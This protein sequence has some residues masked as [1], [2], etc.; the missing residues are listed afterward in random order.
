MDSIGQDT[1]S[2]RKCLVSGFFS[3]AARL[4]PDGSYKSLLG[5]AILYIHPNS[6]LTRRSPE[7]VIYHQVVET[8]KTYMR[9][10]TVINPTW[11]AELAPHFYEPIRIQVPGV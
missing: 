5:N 2:L 9:D 6:I 3:H 7:W 8:T 1:E 4:Q 10:V 11:L